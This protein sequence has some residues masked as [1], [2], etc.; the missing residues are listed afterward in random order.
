LNE[1]VSEQGDNILINLA[2]NE[3]FKSVNIKKI[4]ANIITPQF[5]ERRGDS[6]KVISFNA[7]KA[8]GMM[9]RYI[10][11]N[12]ISNPEDIKAFDLDDYCFNSDLSKEFEWV[13]TR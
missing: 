2:S 8:R 4:N 12:C 6:Y 1:A 10:I 9:S 11:D 3:Y 7:K 13:F 5:K